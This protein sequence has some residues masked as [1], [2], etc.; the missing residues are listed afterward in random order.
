MI[1]RRLTYPVT[2]CASEPNDKRNYK[3]NYKCKGSAAET[4]LNDSRKLS[5]TSLGFGSYCPYAHIERFTNRN[6]EN[7]ALCGYLY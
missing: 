7:R 5:S 1:N 4:R 6:L 2:G 3:C